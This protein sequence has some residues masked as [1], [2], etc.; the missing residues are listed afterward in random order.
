MKILFSFLR[1]KGLE[2][3]WPHLPVRVLIVVEGVFHAPFSS[4]ASPQTGFL[5]VYFE[6]LAGKGLKCETGSVPRKSWMAVSASYHT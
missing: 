4:V 5:P 3:K 2:I 1:L 6:Y